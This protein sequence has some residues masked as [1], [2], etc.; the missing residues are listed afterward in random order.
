MSNR[1]VAAAICGRSTSPDFGACAEGARPH[2]RGHRGLA[3]AL[4]LTAAGALAAAAPASA[5]SVFTENFDGE[6]A[7]IDSSPSQFDVTGSVD[8]VATVN[9]FGIA[10]SGPA[11]G[12]VLDINGTGAAGLITSLSSFAFNA[13]D[14][15][16]LSF[17]LGGS[18]RGDVGDNFITSLLFD[19]VTSYANLSGTGLYSGLSGDDA[20]AKLVESI[21]VPGTTPF[22]SSSIS[23]VAL[24]PGSL[25]FS[26]GSP[27][28]D[29]IGPLL[30]NI[31]LRIDAPRSAA[32]LAPAPVP[33]PS[34]WA[35]LICG[36]AFIGFAM[37]RQQNQAVRVRFG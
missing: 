23:F 21:F 11:S 17:D 5:A 27:S 16:R 36:F 37:R 26:F 1:L 7:M 28:T 32:A 29:N 12:N 3:A 22:T 8:T 20:V 30:D 6:M 19:G 18:Q 24:N 9:P 25:K 31:G 10:V 4:A 13:G 14:R 15:V 35:M 2:G 34:T 33:E